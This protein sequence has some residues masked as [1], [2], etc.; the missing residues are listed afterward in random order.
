MRNV[1]AA[2]LVVLVVALAAQDGPAAESSRAV[3][4]LGD[5]LSVGAAPY[6][7]GRLRGYRIEQAHDI[8]LHAP[9]AA[10][11]VAGRRAALPP[12]LVVSAG[13]NDDPRQVAVFSR[14]V[15][16]LLA[17]AGRGRCVVW[18]LILRPPVS[19]RSYD[20]LNRVLVRASARH[21][22]LVLVDWPALVQ[23]HPRWLSR[24][25]VHVSAAGYRARAAAVAKVVTTRCST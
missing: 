3:L 8:G 25:G 9:E 5:S 24:D 19:G 21:S 18:P 7:K 15:A 14:A 2:S 1:L 10:R 12:V 13:T 22:N 16:R 20:A 17:A 6:L 23:R 11:F 4:D